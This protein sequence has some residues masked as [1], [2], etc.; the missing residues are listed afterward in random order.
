VPDRY[1]LLTTSMLV[2]LVILLWVCLFA[3]HI[4]WTGWKQQQGATSHD[5]SGT[6]RVKNTRMPS[7][8]MWHCEDLVWTDIWRTASH[9][10]HW[11]LALFYLE[12]GGDTFLRNVGSHKIYMVPHPRRWHSSQSL[13]RKPQILLKNTNFHSGF[14]NCECSNCGLMA[15]D[16]M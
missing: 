16:V 6:E 1:L 9:L 4:T 11:F 10:S 8:G 7:S 2:F 12:D 13:L 3:W 14:H 15:C 5:T